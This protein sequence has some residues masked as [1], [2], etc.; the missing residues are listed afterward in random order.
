MFDVAIRLENIPGEMARMGEA[1]GA[2][3]VSVEK[4]GAKRT[5]ASDAT[6]T[7]VIA[8][9]PPTRPSQTTSCPVTNAPSA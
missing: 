7:G 9:R 3:G 6:K 1:L 4:Y 5:S 8:T 2:A